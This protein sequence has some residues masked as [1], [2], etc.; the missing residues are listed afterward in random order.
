MYTSYLC[1]IFFML[2]L[3]L[4]A[5]S[6][7]GD[8]IDSSATGFTVR[9]TVNIQETPLEVYRILVNEISA[10]WNPSHTF[11]GDAQNL[12]IEDRANGCFCESLDSGGS[13]RHMI[14]VHA[15]PGAM[16]RMA[17]ALGPLQSLAVT[18]SLTWALSEEDGDTRVEL[19]YTVTGYRP[20]GLQE[21]A[22]PVDRVLYEQLSRLKNYIENGK[23]E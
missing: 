16:L 11:S 15:N 5:C 4:I 12:Y 23:P 10:W 19:T 22:P 9:N 7:K 3:I 8:V 6:A 14:V 2:N 18:G 20:G 17:G 13:V 21:W 1:K